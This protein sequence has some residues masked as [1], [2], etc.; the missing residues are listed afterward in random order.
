MTADNTVVLDAELGELLPA[1]L[2]AACMRSRHPRGECLFRAGQAPAWM[3][4]V[5]SGEVVLERIGLRGE[6]VILQR[7]RHGFVGEASLQ[8]A[9]YHCDGRVTA[10]AEI[11][12]VPVTAVRQ[13]LQ[14]DPAFAGRWIGMLNRELRRMRMQCERLSLHRVED[15][16][17]HLLDT[18]GREGG[19]PV[20][21][22]LKSLAA[23]LGVT[24]EALYRCIADL[25]RRRLIRR[26]P[27][28]LVLGTAH[29]GSPPQA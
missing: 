16:L 17:L 26:E 9:R 24:H 5:A 21:S 12:Q 28:Q 11:V 22:G 3:Y 15:R 27:G 18:E 6:P 13:A 14:A 19:Y 23:E 7:T 10:P 8:S 4:F 1:G 25:E 20:P 2:H 29:A